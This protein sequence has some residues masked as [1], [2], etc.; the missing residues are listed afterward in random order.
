MR[1]LPLQLSPSSKSNLGGFVGS[2]LFHA[3]IIT[4]F[5]N[6]PS[7]TVLSSKENMTK[8][9]LNTFTPPPPLP[10]A[11]EPIAAPPTPL[12]PEP[13][14]VPEPVVE[15]IV[16]PVILPEPKPEPKIEPKPIE[17]PK[18]KPKKQK[19]VVKTEP[20]LDPT[21]APPQP[22]IQPTIPI[23]AEKIGSVTAAPI[24]SFIAPIVGEFNFASS[25]GDERFSKMQAAIKKHQ[26]YP[27]RAVK[28]KHQ[29]VVEISFLFKT[30]GSVDD[31]KII[32]SS[33]YDSL[34]EA[35]IETIRRAFKDFPMLDK[36]YIIKIPMSYKLI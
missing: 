26:K 21:P 28:M 35:A 32:K 25:A 27:K 4:A 18:P 29:G 3:I 1:I 22:V 7:Q 13:V 12:P 19:S 8:I 23:K 11:P 16:E 33:G 14:V 17:K 9:N 5:I 15:P 36:D 30:N 24:S 2:A 34:D 20:V 6:F 10:P 31:I